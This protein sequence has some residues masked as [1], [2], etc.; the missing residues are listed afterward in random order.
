M[1][2]HLIEIYLMK[3]AKSDQSFLTHAK[4]CRVAWGTMTR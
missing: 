4:L 2:L 1:L 3:A